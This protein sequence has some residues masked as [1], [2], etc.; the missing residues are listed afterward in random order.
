[1][2]LHLSCFPPISALLRSAS[3]ECINGFALT[4]VWSNPLCYSL[5]YDY[6]NI[7]KARIEI[8]H[9]FRALEEYNL[10]FTLVKP[11]LQAESFIVVQIL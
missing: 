3:V 4:T 9:W 10:L 2:Q 7:S 6:G 8:V 11:G 5:D 1:M